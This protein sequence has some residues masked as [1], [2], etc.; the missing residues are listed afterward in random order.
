M[1]GSTQTL[2]S[3]KSDCEMDGQVLE[4]DLRLKAPF[5]GLVAGPTSSGKSHIVFRIIKYRD[6]MIDTQ[7]KEVIYCLPPGQQ[8]KTPDF[9]KRDRQVKFHSGLPD[10]TKIN[11]AMPR[12]VILDDLMSDVN[13]EVMDLFTR[14]SHHK[15]ISVLF[16]VQN[17]F[18]G[19]SKLF[20]TIS[21]NAHYIILT[22]NP[23]DKNQISTLAVQLCPE[24]SAALKNAFRDA[25]K[26]AYTYLLF[27]TSQKC[28]DALRF[29]TNIFPED[30]PRNIIYMIE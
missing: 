28:P 18:F 21:L 27:D 1:D 6:E 30:Q 26:N 16:L 10:F 19:G 7:M 29:R 13:N 15:N 12:L 17:I 3:N 23:R 11:D 2:I 20:R 25:T 4:C 9:I 8:I 5:T 24:N 14:G 22:K